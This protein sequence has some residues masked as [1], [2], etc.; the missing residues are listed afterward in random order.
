MSKQCLHSSDRYKRVFGT[1]SRA[2]T[3]THKRERRR[4]A[5]GMSAAR[6]AA[7]GERTRRER[8]GRNDATRRGSEKGSRRTDLLPTLRGC[9]PACLYLPARLPARLPTCP[10]ASES[11]RRCSGASDFHAALRDNRDPFLPRTVTR[12]TLARYVVTCLVVDRATIILFQPEDGRSRPI[13]GERG[14]REREEGR[15][16]NFIAIHVDYVDGVRRKRRSRRDK[17]GREVGK[18]DRSDGR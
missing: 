3:R 18:G 8:E 5:R 9:L 4:D 14:G 12:K 16:K 15:K 1:L 10:P 17:S 7:R 13:R 2:H 6:D 11:H